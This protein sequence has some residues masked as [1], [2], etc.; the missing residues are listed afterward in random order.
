MLTPEITFDGSTSISFYTKAAN[1]GWEDGLEVRVSS[2][3][4]STNLGSTATDVGDFTTLLLQVNPGLDGNYPAG[5]TQFTLTNADG[6]PS[7]GSGRIAFRYYVTSGGPS[8]SNSDIIGIDSVSITAA[9]VAGGLPSTE[10]NTD[11]VNPA[12]SNAR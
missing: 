3:G 11:P 4:A 9:A 6:I 8:G 10:S 1:A 12:Q 7:S 5:W 2:A